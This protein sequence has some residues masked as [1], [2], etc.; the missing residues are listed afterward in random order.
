MAMSFEWPWQYRFPPFFTLQ[1]N[2]DTRQKQ[3]AAWCSLVLSFCR[4][5]K[6]SSMTVMEAQES[7]LFNNVKLQ[8]KLPVESIQVVLEELRKKGGFSLWP[9]K[10]NEERKEEKKKKAW[11]PSP[12]A[13][14]GS[15][16]HMNE[17]F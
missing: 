11:G 4:L 7:P 12:S 1:P 8:R 14:F 5:H 6:Q 15:V 3:L 13:A 9:Q 2:V 16:H 17:T 10:I